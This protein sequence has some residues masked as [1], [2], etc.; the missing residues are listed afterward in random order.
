[1][2]TS[3]LLERLVKTF[4]QTFAATFALTFVAPADVADASGWKA[5]AAAALVASLAAAISAVTSLASRKIGDP[6][7]AS[8]VATAQNPP[9]QMQV[10]SSNPDSVHGLSPAQGVSPFLN[11]AD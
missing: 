1:M 4:V 3:D 2:F 10:T 6:N 8:M 5:A 9:P 11:E 7:T